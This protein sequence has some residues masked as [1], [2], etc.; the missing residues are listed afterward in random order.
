MPKPLKLKFVG[1]GTAFNSHR[2]W[3]VLGIRSPDKD[4]DLLLSPD[5][6]TASEV[7]AAA[8]Y[9]KKKLDEIVS[10]AKRR[11]PPVVSRQTDSNKQR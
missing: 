3:I 11:F 2:A 8:K 6:A 1:D 5:C 7:E 4:G 9:L 10:S